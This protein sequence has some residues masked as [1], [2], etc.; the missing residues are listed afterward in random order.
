MI[1]SVNAPLTDTAAWD[2]DAAAQGAGDVLNG[3]DGND[4]VIG[5]AGAVINGGAGNDQLDGL[6]GS[7]L[8]GGAGNDTIGG[9]IAV[10]T[11]N[12]ASYSVTP[13]LTYIGQGLWAPVIEVKD[14]RPGSP[15]GTDMVFSNTI[16]FAD[17]VYSAPAAPDSDALFLAAS[18]EEVYTPETPADVSVPGTPTAVLDANALLA[19][20]V[21]AASFAIAGGAD[22]S[23]F[24]IDPVTGQLS[25]NT[26]PDFEAPT[27][28]ASVT[29]GEGLTPSVAGDNVYEVVLRVVDANGVADLVGVLVHVEDVFGELAAT[30]D[31]EVVDG[32]AENDLLDDGGMIGVTL[33]GLAGDDTLTTHSAAIVNGGAGVDTVELIR[34]SASTLTLTETAGTVSVSDGTQL[35]QVEALVYTGSVGADVFNASGVT[36]LSLD[37]NGNEG[38]DQLIGGAAADVLVGGAG[39]DVLMGGAGNDAL[40]ASLIPTPDA[41]NEP[42]PGEIDTLTG[43]AGNDLIVGDGASTVVVFS[44]NRAAYTL[45]VNALTGAVTVQDNLGTDGVDTVSGFAE[46][47]FADQSLDANLNPI[48][49]ANVAPVIDSN[50]GA[51]S[52]AVTINE[53]T[54]AVTT[55]HATDANGQALTYAINGGADAA[56]FQINATTGALSFKAA[57]NAEAAGDVGANNVYDVIVQASDGTLTDTQAIAVTVANVNEFAVTVPT[58]VDAGVNH[59]A[60]G[61]AAGTLVGVTAR[62]TDADIGTTVAYSIAG[63]NAASSAFKIDAATGVVSVN[64][65]AAD[66]AAGR[67]HAEHHGAGHQLRRLGVQPGLL[68]RDRRGQCGAGD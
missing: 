35:T 16:Q 34:D 7:T 39:S 64:N 57:P 61:A 44:G 45:T 60:S 8:T 25:F 20:G 3:G 23:A 48:G 13:S 67:W 11:G 2:A 56:L 17:G 18:H 33:N 63:F 62:A 32:T 29:Q 50:G 4:I 9:D 47:K 10:Y 31:G 53:N 65:P 40:Y 66:H 59:V 49:N 41:P 54:T 22:A 42:V 15:D 36:T 6:A 52:A 1:Q 26:P 55:V 37:L 14:L 19:F 24:T 5:S 12:Q 46:L 30:V 43:G 68:D 58:D 38:N 21:T 27:D 28:G 51:A